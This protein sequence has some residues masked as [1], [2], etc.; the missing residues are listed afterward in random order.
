MWLGI[1]LLVIA[2][3]FFFIPIIFEKKIEYHPDWLVF[4]ILI[5]TFTGTVLFIS[6]IQ[7]KQ[8]TIDCYKGNYPYKQAIQYK[9]EGSKLI[10]QDTIYIKKG[11]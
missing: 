10:S 9:Y 6:D 5:C 2:I 1:I 8:T 11:K 4:L 3:I 7:E